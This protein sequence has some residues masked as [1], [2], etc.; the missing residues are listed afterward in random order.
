MRLTNIGIVKEL[1]DKH[2]IKFQ[3]KFGQNFLINPEV[4]FRIAEECGA[5]E[6][7]CVLEIGPGIGTLTQE[8]CEVAKKVVAVE[9]DTGLIPV[10]AETLAEYDNVEV[11]NSDIM[12]TDIEKLFKEKFGDN[13][14]YVCAN[15]PYYITTPILM[16]LLESRLPFKKMTFMV[17]KEVAE[18]LCATPKDSDYGAVTASVSY[19]GEVRKLFNVSAGNFMPAP[20]VDSAV[21]QISLYEK[22][23]V[24]VADEKQF[25]SLIRAAFEQ[26]RKTLVNALNGKVGISKEQ[27]A[28][29]ITNIGLDVNIR[30]ERLGIEEFAKLSDE[31]TRLKKEG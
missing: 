9:I 3:K 29:A 31:I 16:L 1:M 2:G 7:D 23:P 8:L 14:V 26:R 6:N 15:L 27:I 11:I 10:L 5:C 21:I 13:D 12:K 18:R 17:Q 19:Y 20:K 4:P 25:F 24:D 22:P 28:S 30:G